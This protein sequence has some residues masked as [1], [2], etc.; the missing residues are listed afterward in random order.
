MRRRAMMVHSAPGGGGSIRERYSCREVWMVP[1]RGAHV[2][3]TGG[4]SGIGL[5]TGCLVARRGAPVSLMAR[6]ARRL[7][8]AAG[9]V[10]APRAG[11]GA[12][13]GDARD[14]AAV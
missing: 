1:L 9:R 2:V 11:P 10:R 13:P 4:S 3:I 14:P 12:V 7:Q 8:Q 6:D 5:A